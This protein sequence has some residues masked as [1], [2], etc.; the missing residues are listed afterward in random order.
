MSED[1]DGE[2]LDMGGP[3][4]CQLEELH[5]VPLHSINEDPLSVLLVL[6]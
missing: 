6:S 4:G 3:L 2:V 5:V 1:A